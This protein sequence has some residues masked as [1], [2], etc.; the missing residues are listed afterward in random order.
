MSVGSLTLT[1]DIQVKSTPSCL[2]LLQS[3]LNMSVTKIACTEAS[4]GKVSERKIIFLG[5]LL[6]QH[7][8]VD[9]NG[10]TS[11][12]TVCLFINTFIANLII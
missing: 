3:K 11:T 10:S 4:S 8:S 2:Q 5:K 7:M 12:V 6:L 9:N 1:N